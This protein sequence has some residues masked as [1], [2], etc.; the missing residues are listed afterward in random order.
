[1][2]QVAQRR[3]VAFVEIDRR[4]SLLGSALARPAAVLV[5]HKEG[6]LMGDKSPKSKN[7]AKKQSDARKDSKKSAAAAKQMKSK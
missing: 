7:K 3:S 1:V 6:E 4:H 5:E 2:T